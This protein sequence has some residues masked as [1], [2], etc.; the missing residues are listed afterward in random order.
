MSQVRITARRQLMQ[1]LIRKPARVEVDG[2][3]VGE[4]RWGQ[5]TVFEV[6]TGD[7]QLTMSFPYLGRP[8]TGEATA[9]LPVADN[10][11]VNVQY[12][13]PWIVTMGGSLKITPEPSQP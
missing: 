9:A 13:S 5:T 2:Q 12:K 4:A 11:T 6:P 1:F 3:P 10:Q 7:H 8:R